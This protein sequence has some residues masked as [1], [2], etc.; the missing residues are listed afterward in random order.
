[1]ALSLYCEEPSVDMLAFDTAKWLQ[2]RSPCA[3]ATTKMLPD[4]YLM[5][6]INE[7]CGDF[8]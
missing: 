2:W 6:T 7:S 4:Q 1:M 8:P 3:L 5:D